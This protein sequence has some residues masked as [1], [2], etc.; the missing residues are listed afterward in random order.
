LDLQIQIDNFGNCDSIQI[1]DGEYNTKT[2][3]RRM[4]IY[5]ILA[6]GNVAP[7]SS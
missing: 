7:F 4:P 2:A 3:E 1:Y 6:L 5:R